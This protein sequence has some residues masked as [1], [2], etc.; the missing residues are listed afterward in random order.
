[1]RFYSRSEIAEITEI[2]MES[3]NFSRDVKDTLAKWG[4]GFDWISRKGVTIT[5]IPSSPEERL[6][7]ILVRQFH[8][9]VQVD[10]YAFA[11]FV[12]AFSD[13][14]GFACMPWKE[15]EHHFRD[16]LGRQ[17][18]ERTMRNWAKKLIEKQII[19]KGTEGSFWKTEII[20]NRKI[21]TTVP[22]EEV[23]VYNKRRTEL[24]NELAID[25]I[26]RDKS[27]SYEKA[28]R[29]AWKDVYYCLWEEFH[30][31]YYSCKTFYFTAW[32]EQGTLAEVYELTREIS[33]KENDCSGKL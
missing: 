11:C 33:R 28:L 8:V 18:D 13:I 31:C 3:H 27:L 12:T 22:E 19:I 23:E 9:D 1:M 24:L 32:N 21:R 16:Y 25:T 10:M 14:P 2:S 6:Q 26:K 17:V 7:E 15:R 4:Y 20:D 30:C 29:A 5:H